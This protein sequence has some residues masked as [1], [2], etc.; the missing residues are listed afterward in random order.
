M[1]TALRGTGELI[2]LHNEQHHIVSCRRRR[3][4]L[5][6]KIWVDA[7]ALPTEA[8]LILLRACRRLSVETV[9]VANKNV[10]V[11]D[12]PLVSF[13]RVAEGPDIADAFI[14]ESSAPGDICVTADIPLAARL[15]DKGLTVI[16]PRGDLYSVESIGERLATRD[17]MAGLRDAGVQTGGPPP[18]SLKAK[19]RF[20]STLDRELSKAVRS[21]EST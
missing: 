10:W 3:T 20:A 1:R 19:Q 9:F 13:V 14:V 12:D 16:D 5:P 21:A 15:V 4:W 8:K 17:L 6:V 11:E 7:D 18:F 2:G